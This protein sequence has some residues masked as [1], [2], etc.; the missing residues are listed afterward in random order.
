MLMEHG[1]SI[2]LF[3]IYSLGESTANSDITIITL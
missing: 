3:E 1:V 2:T